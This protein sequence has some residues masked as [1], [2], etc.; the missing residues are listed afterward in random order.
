MQD[1]VSVH[2]TFTKEQ[3]GK[4]L[5]DALIMS[6]DEFNSIT[7]EKIEEQKQ[8]RLDNWIKAV[9]TPVEAVEPTK[10]DLESQQASIDEQIAQL[11]SQKVV[12]SSK[13][14]AVSIVE[15]SPV[16]KVVVK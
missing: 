2:I 12:L 8:Q 14:E 6:L 3:D 7:P 13:L 10:E 15:V 11:Q 4:T 16:K 5:T 9:N 1:K